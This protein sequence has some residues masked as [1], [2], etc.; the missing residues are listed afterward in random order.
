MFKFFC[1]NVICLWQDARMVITL[2]LSACYCKFICFPCYQINAPL[3]KK[4]E[5][6]QVDDLMKQIM[7][8]TKLDENHDT[9]TTR[10]TD[11]EIAERLAKLK[12]L[13]PSEWK[14]FK[15]PRVMN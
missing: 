6:E 10:V 3:P 1:F 9:N 12:D 5:V 14:Y 13:D 4:S 15:F 11:K 2:L 7:A 8:E